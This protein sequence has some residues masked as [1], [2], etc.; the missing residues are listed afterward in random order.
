MPSTALD[1]AAF[2]PVR[3]QPGEGVLGLI[4][5]DGETIVIDDARPTIRASSTASASTTASL[6]FIAAPIQL[7]GSAAVGVLAVQPDDARRRPARRIARASSRW[8]PT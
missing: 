6:P 3:Y 1:A 7:G 8:S 4:L 2:T 5:E